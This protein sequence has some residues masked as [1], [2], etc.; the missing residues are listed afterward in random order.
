VE[1]ND[2]LT[3]RI[4]GCAI[5]VH[6][7]LGPGLLESAYE[8]CMAHEMTLQDIA[9]RLQVPT[10]IEYKGLRLDC[11]YKADVVVQE[12]VIV[13]LK[14][15]EALTALHHAQLLT[16]MKVSRTVIGLLINFNVPRLIDGVKR[17]R[18]QPS[19]RASR[20]RLR[21]PFILSAPSESLNGASAARPVPTIAPTV[22]PTVQ[23]HR[24]GVARIGAAPDRGPDM[25][26][27]SQTRLVDSMP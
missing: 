21:S 5:E 1:D 25:N 11:A 7:T 2:P 3:H 15:V 27:H 23:R 26:D 14:S 12:R 4:M 22:V 16:Y 9:F 6:R 10:P 13:E 8:Q 17:F 19:A 24:A 18:I 20:H